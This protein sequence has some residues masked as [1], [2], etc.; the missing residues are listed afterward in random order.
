MKISFKIRLIFSNLLITILFSCGKTEFLQI[1][2]AQITKENN[3]TKQ[4]EGTLIY[5]NINNEIIQENFNNENSIF[6]IETYKNNIIPIL[7]KYENT[8]P[9]YC[10]NP[11]YCGII[12]PIITEFSIHSAF[13]SYIYVRILLGSNENVATTQTY[14]RYFNWLKFYEKICE[15]SNPF[16]LDSD[17]ICSDICNN[18][19]SIYSIRLK[20]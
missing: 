17:R 8:N 11:T 20:S 6:F 12:H 7:L 5:C 3:F 1:D 13:C 18:E 19:F 15:Y 2:T 16:L 4:N 9:S 10:E 14:C